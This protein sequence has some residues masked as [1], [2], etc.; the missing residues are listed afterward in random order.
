M[1]MFT[2]GHV[3]ECSEKDYNGLYNKIYR[4]KKLSNYNYDQ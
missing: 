4:I 3:P 2:K 1:H